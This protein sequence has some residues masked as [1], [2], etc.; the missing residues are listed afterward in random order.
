[1]TCGQ[2]A[3]SLGATVQRAPWLSLLATSVGLVASALPVSTWFAYFSGSAERGQ[4]WRL[5]SCHFVH[6]N[7][8][9]LWGDLLAFTVWASLVEGESRR[10]LIST[11]VLGAPLL[12]SALALTCP[13][14]GEYRGLSGLDTALVIEL[15]LLRGFVRIE[16]GPE[17]GFGPWLTRHLGR[18]FL[19]R[20]A[21]PV[22]A[23]RR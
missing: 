9:H 19:R 11:L 4:L 14:L 17:S 2:R 18:S 5:W 21:W 1:M 13:E 3:R 20:V 16:H 12:T 15:I 22:W 6:Y 7:G 23:F 10:A 8:A